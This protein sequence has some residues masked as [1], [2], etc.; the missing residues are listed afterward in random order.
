M[1]ILANKFF[2]VKSIIVTNYV[3]I[4]F[5]KECLIDV[6]SN[7]VFVKRVIIGSFVFIVDYEVF[8]V[9]LSTGIIDAILFLQLIINMGIIIYSN[10]I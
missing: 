3:F 2:R 9:F 7:N 10:Y 6:D 5:T 1:L 4:F 8:I